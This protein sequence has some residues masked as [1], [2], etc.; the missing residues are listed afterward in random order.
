MIY[1]AYD[2]RKKVY[3]FIEVDDSTDL[4]EWQKENPNYVV[5]AV[6]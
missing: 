6:F 4:C 3:T 2:Q 1:K 5:M